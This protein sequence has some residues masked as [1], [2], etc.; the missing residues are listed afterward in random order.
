[1][2]PIKYLYFSIIFLLLAI[3]I[4]NSATIVMNA[5]LHEKKVQYIFKKKLD[6]TTDYFKRIPK[7]NFK[8]A[9]KITQNASIKGIS[10]L[11]FQNEELK[12]WSDNDVPYSKVK[13][14]KS[15]NNTIVQ[16]A[17]SYYYVKVESQSG[18]RLVGLIH[19]ANDYPYENKFLLNGLHPDFSRASAR[20]I[21][22]PENSES[23]PIVDNDEKYAFSVLFTEFG[24]TNKLLIRILATIFLFTGTILFFLYLRFAVAGWKQKNNNL[25]ILILILTF[26]M[27]RWFFISFRILG[28]SF[29]LFDPFIYATKVAPTFGDLILNSFFFLFCAY[30]VYKFIRIPE[31]YLDNNFNRNA[32]IGIVNFG[33]VLVL[34]FVNSSTRGIITDSS[35]SVV[36]HNISQITIASV[37]AYVIFGVQYFGFFLLVLW[38]NNSLES[39]KKY[40][41]VIHFG[42]L[43]AIFYIFSFALNIKIDV[44]T[45]LFAVVI[46]S[47][48]AIMR[49]RFYGNSIFSSL[50]LLLLV[51]SIYVLAFTTH[52]S[53]I[54]ENLINQ[55]FAEN[56]ASEHDPIAEY[57]FEEITEDMVNDRNMASLLEAEGFDRN[58][59][60]NYLSRNYFKGYLKKYDLG[61]TVC[62]PKDSVLF[63]IPSNQWYPCY[64]YF[65]DYISNF[66]IKVPGVPFYYLEN[67]TG[68]MSYFGWIKY[69]DENM[70]EVSIFVQLDAKS[71]L[72][73]QPLGYPEL[74]LDKKV[75]RKSYYEGY[76]YAKYHKGNL[77]SHS[78]DYGYSLKSDVFI[79]PSNEEYYKLKINGYNH[80]VY[81]QNKENLV[82]VSEKS[83]QALDRVVTFSYVFVFYY[84]IALVT[85]FLLLSRYRHLGFR[86]SLRNKIQFSVILILIASLLLIA[87]STTWFNIR[88][89][90]Q[91]Q[92]RI[93]KEKIQSVYVELEHKLSF[94][95]RLT[96]DWSTEKYENLEQLLIKFSD[97]FY[98]DI[99]LYSPDG[100][101]IA[102]SRPEVFQLGLQNMKMEPMAYYKL[103]AEKLAQY[104]HR[105][106]IT[107]LS[108]LS[109]YI[110]FVNHEGKLL[111]YLNLPY[112]TKQQEL[113]EDI[114]TL[115]V[116]IINIYVLLILLTIIIAVVISNQITKPLEMLQARF[117]GLT[118][119][120][121][122][123]QIEYHRYDEIGK[124]VNEYN[125]MVKEL[126]KSVELLAKSERETAWR[127][128]A[129]Q[130]AHEIKNP[131][132]PMRLSVQQLQRAWDDRKENF[133]NYLLRVTQTL[134]EQIDNLSTIASEFS[135]FAKMPSPEIEHVNLSSVLYKTVDL[136]KGNERVSVN[137]DI[138]DDN[139]FVKADAEQ[140]NRVFINIIKN[141]IQAIPE[142]TGGVID[143]KLSKSK[144]LAIIELRDNGKGIPEEIR[145]KL[146]MPNFTTKTSGMGLG[147][148]IVKNTLE[149][150]SGDISF[151]TE[152]GKG[153]IFK[154]NIP[155]AGV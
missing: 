28:D 52:Y 80:L 18:Y 128:M 64:E 137:L 5:Q 120:G 117:R 38:A 142:E 33:L 6:K 12:F 76:S 149:Q 97:V 56:L 155:L 61:I 29:Y 73:T 147:L 30:L 115:T 34:W 90:N 119:G 49:E 17:N 78:G 4:S 136:F 86:D 143:I 46:F 101:L 85:I 105:E 70:G 1:M 44:Y 14:D 118:L 55:S 67:L 125:R 40:R 22:E 71:T 9:A 7:S 94:E 103:H 108:Y 62:D 122:Y 83:A 132:T 72:T 8:K 31:K 100:N 148:A 126:E 141:G 58:E 129:K 111:A 63:D 87:G 131:L 144:D 151:S 91:T 42:T 75:Q 51:F 21:L 66:G 89:Y 20:V 140:L 127:E 57:L 92:F 65:E 95:D 110:P 138:K 104:I 96:A 109:A 113:Q 41:L 35:L 106:R 84:L 11:V 47:L 48:V 16:L 130:V 26:I 27:V 107:N 139:L 54:K 43:L 50:V 15:K 45:I 81:Q 68:L 74:L 77:I 37:V 88:K 69:V 3:I 2:K 99:N 116:A 112:F 114:T 134:I 39:V 19:I 133:E 82:V 98:S 152:M 154:I 79:I 153:T 59:V 10:I 135:N 60:Y 123:E 146:F 36:M 23:Y 124:L 93:L 25:T 102:S 145:T 24:D 32:W 121:H 53:R 13:F 150:I